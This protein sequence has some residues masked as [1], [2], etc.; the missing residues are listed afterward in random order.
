MFLGLAV[1]GDRPNQLLLSQ[2]AGTSSIA[3]AELDAW[4]GLIQQRLQ[5][6]TQARSSSILADDGSRGCAVNIS[7]GLCSASPGAYDGNEYDCPS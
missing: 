3:T 2:W 4:I 1:K 6:S 7:V 5:Y